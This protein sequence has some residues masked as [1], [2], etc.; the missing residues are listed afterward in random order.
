MPL[1]ASSRTDP[2]GLALDDLEQRRSWAELE[3]RI[4]RMANGL[5]DDFG[6]GP[7]DHVALLMHNRAEAIEGLAAGIAAGVWVTPINWHLTPDEIATVLGRNPSTVRSWLRRALA[8]LR[9][10]YRDA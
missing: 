5:R 1:F 10:D 3:D 7:D 8:N 6:L 9:E 4:T 2:Q